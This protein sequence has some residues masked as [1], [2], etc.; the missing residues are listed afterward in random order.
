LEIEIRFFPNDEAVIR[1]E[2][3]W[4][5][6]RPA[7]PELTEKD[8][9]ECPKVFRCFVCQQSKGWK[10]LGAVVVLQRLCLDCRSALEREVRCLIGV[11]S[12]HGHHHVRGFP[13]KKP[14]SMKNPNRKYITG[15]AEVPREEKEES[16]VISG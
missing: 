9:A 8:L 15:S 10:K 6:P 14:V 13:L 2:L 16:N 4:D 3:G 12:V 1:I 7:I 5:K 11:D